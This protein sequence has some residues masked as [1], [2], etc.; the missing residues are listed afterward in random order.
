[1]IRLCCRVEIRREWLDEEGLLGASTWTVEKVESI[2]ITGDGDSLQDT[3][4]IKLPKNARWGVSG[5]EIPIRR[6]D[7]VRVWLG[8]DGVLKL[9]FVGYVKE[10]AA[11]TP[12]VIT[13]EDEMMRLRQKAAKQKMYNSVTLSQLLDEQLEGMDIVRYDRESEAEVQLGC[14]RIEATTVAGVLSELKQNYGIT[15]CFALVDEVPTLYCFTVL[16][17]LRRNAGRFEEG[18]NIISNSLEYRRSEDVQVKIKGVSIQEDNSRIE[19]S[20][21]EGEERTIYR[22]GLNMNEL[23][24]AVKNELKR[25]K[26]SGLQGDFETFGM[27]RVEKMDVL[28]LYAA[29]TRGRYRV[30]GVNISFGSGGYRQK[31]QLKER[32]VEL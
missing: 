27:P 10:V 22:Y 16:P 2:E 31:I 1:M 26:W 25:D 18:V 15:S 20:E 32:L 3:C 30:K 12:T 14:L 23:K 9:R 21:G 28:D 6:G 13:C 19:Y 8:Y 24:I 11:K 5:S 29:G 17:Q 7:N 4:V